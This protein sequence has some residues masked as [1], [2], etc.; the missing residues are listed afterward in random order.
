V[1]AHVSLAIEADKLAGTIVFFA[2][3]DL[4]RG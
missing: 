2:L 3:L 4:S 1:G